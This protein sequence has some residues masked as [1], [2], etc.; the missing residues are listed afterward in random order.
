MGSIGEGVGIG[1]IWGGKGLGR[2]MEGVR[3]S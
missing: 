1:M 2:D 3:C